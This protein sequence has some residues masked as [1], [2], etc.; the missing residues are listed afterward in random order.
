VTVVVGLGSMLNALF[1]GHQATV[2]RNGVAI[3]AADD[4]GPAPQR[5]VANLVA[6]VFLLVLALNAAVASSLLGLVPHGLVSAL[7]GLA[8][9]NSLIESL[10]KS[11]TG[12]LPMG[13]LF[14]FAI[15]ASPLQLLGIGSTLWAL[16]GGMAVSLLLERQAL[17]RAVAAGPAPAPA[18]PASLRRPSSRSP[19]ADQPA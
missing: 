10:K 16:L 6:T 12:A 2:A 14:A 5:Y 19:G 13:S 11:V 8:I 1:C 17:V 15:A 4:A 3:L 9:L 18:V 7:A